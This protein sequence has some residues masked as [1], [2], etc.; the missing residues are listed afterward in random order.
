[1]GAIPI[2]I[3]VHLHG[4]RSVGLMVSLLFIVKDIST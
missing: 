1:M 3:A 4:H 2:P